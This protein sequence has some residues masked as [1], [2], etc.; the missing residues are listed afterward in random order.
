M[1]SNP[2]P[3]FVNPSDESGKDSEESQDQEEDL[4]QASI[5][6]KMLKIA[7]KKRK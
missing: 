2:E 1:S 4:V 7:M 3:T 6:N 5:D